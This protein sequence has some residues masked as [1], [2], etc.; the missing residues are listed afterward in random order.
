MKDDNY[1]DTPETNS[2][3]RVSFTS[4]K[5]EEGKVVDY[6]LESVTM[7][8]TCDTVRCNDQDGPKNSLPR[9]S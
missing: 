3:D 8:V 6:L 2:L 9:L 1:L 7:G 5:V 4:P